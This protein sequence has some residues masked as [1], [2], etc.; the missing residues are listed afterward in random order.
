MFLELNLS[1]SESLI[2]LIRFID[3]QEFEKSFQN[4][5][6]T[7]DTLC[8][9]QVAM[10]LSKILT[11]HGFRIVAEELQKSDSS[12]ISTGK[13]DKDYSVCWRGQ[14]RHKTVDKDMRDALVN[15]QCHL[16]FCV[17]TL[18]PAGNM[19]MC[20]LMTHNCFTQDRVGS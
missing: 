12:Q 7:M 4:S 9:S 19:K 1:V 20:P 8:D 3:R 13:N 16:V 11:D 18:F 2:E 15:C 14:G 17:P 5:T 10:D 6:M